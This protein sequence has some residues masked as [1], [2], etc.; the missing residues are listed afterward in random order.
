MHEISVDSLQIISIE[1]DHALMLICAHYMLSINSGWDI[2][3][4]WG[5]LNICKKNNVMW[6]NFLKGTWMKASDGLAIH[7]ITYASFSKR[8]YY[9]RRKEKWMGRCKEWIGKG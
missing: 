6:G 9:G 4:S 5:L 2:K 1:P 3:L 7:C 8:W